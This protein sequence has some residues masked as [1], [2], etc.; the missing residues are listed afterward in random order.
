MSVSMPTMAYTVRGMAKTIAMARLTFLSL[1]SLRSAS[2]ESPS[3]TVYPAFTMALTT[4]SW[5][6][7]ESS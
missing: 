1:A 3:M 6:V 2:V 5:D 4:S 7:L